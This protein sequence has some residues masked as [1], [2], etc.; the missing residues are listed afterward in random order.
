[1]NK[2]EEV[3]HFRS[4]FR[5]CG[6]DEA[7]KIKLVERIRD[8]ALEYLPQSAIEK[9]PPPYFSDEI[10]AA[11]A[12]KG[13]TLE[14]NLNILGETGVYAFC[15]TATARD[16]SLTS[17]QQ[18]AANLLNYCTMALEKDAVS[19][20]LQ[21]WILDAYA[22]LDSDAVEG[23]KKS[24]EALVTARITSAKNKRIRTEEHHGLWREW[25]KEHFKQFPYSKPNDTAYAVFERAKQHVP[26]MHI[27][28][29]GNKYSL[30]TIESVI[31]GTKKG[32][33]NEPLK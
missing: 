12:A 22:G 21:Q 18:S 28:V 26:P 8:V 29:N 1:M 27:M 13:I 15:S 23:R 19:D 20:Q 31:T 11:Y 5:Q 7:K 25:A 4:Y 17:S 2:F 6:Y 30:K 16:S 10:R 24:S 14:W 9:V 33:K 3:P 32:I